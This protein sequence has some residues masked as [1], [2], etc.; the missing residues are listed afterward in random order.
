FPN[1]PDGGDVSDWLNMGHSKDDLE[2]L[3]YSAPDWSPD[4]TTD[5][6]ASALGD[7]APEEAKEKPASPKLIFVKI[8]DWI[9]R[10]PPQRDWAVPDRF[11]LRNVSLLSGEGSIGK[12]L[13]LMQLTAA[14]VLGRGW[15]DTLPEPGDAI[16]LNAEDEDDELWRRYSD[17]VRLY[18]A[19]LTDLKD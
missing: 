12:S 9:G 8:E 3:C 13:V 1:L 11:P 18:D 17:I 15:L 6:D 16:Y 7:P 14:H 10:D 4:T 5:D 2:D 19:S